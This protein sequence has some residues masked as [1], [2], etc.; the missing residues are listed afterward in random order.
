MI[1]FDFR[2]KLAVA[3]MVMALV[4]LLAS[5]MTIYLLIAFLVIYL[6]VQ[7]IGR[8]ALVYLAVALVLIGLRLYSNGSGITPLL[9]EMF[10][11]MLLRTVLM[12]MAAEPIFGMPPGEV[13]AVCKKMHAPDLLSLP[14][15]FMLR[16]LPA[17]RGEFGDVFDSLR[18]RGLLSIRHP[19]RAFEYM[20]TPVIFR[21]SRI[22]EELAASAESRGISFPGAH[23]CRRE[24][25][26]EGKD[27]LLVVLS[28]V[29]F[30]MCLFVDRVVLI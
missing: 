18:M 6:T 20:V 17:I 11:F 12:L 7:G 2:A 21:S 3:G 13:V 15:T 5:D 25:R 9:P 29:I 23:S 10:L 4:A 8:H 19:G 22:A 1:H 14:L 27:G 26:F 28:I 16:F 24:I 30:G